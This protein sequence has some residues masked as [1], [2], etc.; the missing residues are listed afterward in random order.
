MKLEAKKQKWQNL[1]QDVFTR[2][3]IATAEAGGGKRG[4]LVVVVL[5]ASSSPS[6]SS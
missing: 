4:V 1:F 6:S 5:V 3:K 2:A